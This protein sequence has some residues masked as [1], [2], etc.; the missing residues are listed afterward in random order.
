MMLGFS[1][2]GELLWASADRFLERAAVPLLRKVAAVVSRSLTDTIVNPS[3]VGFSSK[4]SYETFQFCDPVP[5]FGDFVNVWI[6]TNR[7]IINFVNAETG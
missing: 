4:F 1:L 2:D 3:R 7:G 6:V 5:K